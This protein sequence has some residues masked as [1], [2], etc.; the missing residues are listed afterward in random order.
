MMEDKD[1]LLRGVVEVDE[2]YLGGTRRK[3]NK[4]A[5]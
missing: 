1:G 2:T 3:G 5:M 4:V